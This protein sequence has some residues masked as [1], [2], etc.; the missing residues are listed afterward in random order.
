MVITEQKRC[1]ESSSLE[2]KIIDHLSDLNLQNFN[3]T[4]AEKTNFV[5]PDSVSMQQLTHERKYTIIITVQHLPINPFP[6]AFSLS[7]PC[8]HNESVAMVTVAW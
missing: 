5:R 2:E 6:D 4:R 1:F 8:L 7:H 3:V